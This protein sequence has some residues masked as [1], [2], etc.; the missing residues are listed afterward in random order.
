MFIE[1]HGDAPRESD[2][3]RARLRRERER[4]VRERERERVSRRES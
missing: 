3:E 1:A 4:A 2:C